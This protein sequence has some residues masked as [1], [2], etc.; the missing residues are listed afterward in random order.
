MSSYFQKIL[1]WIGLVLVTVPV[2]QM[3]SYPEGYGLDKQR[4]SSI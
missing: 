1:A 3:S 4:T 2:L